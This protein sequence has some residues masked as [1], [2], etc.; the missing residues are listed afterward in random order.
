MRVAGVARGRRGFLG[1]GGLG[2]AMWLV[3]RRVGGGVGASG[4]GE[5]VN[6]EVDGADEVE[7]DDGSPGVALGAEGLRGEVQLE[8]L[9]QRRLA[10]LG[11]PW[12]A[13]ALCT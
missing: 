4:V 6:D 11:L 7:V 2:A 3:C 5:E 8:V 1:A 10:R 12:T 9:E 13:V